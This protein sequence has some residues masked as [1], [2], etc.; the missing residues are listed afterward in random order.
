MHK[1]PSV[2]IINQNI[3]QRQLLKNAL[4]TIEITQISETKD[5][6]SAIEIL[7]SEAF[8]LIITDI[9]LDQIDGWRLT[10]LIRSGVLK[11]A[12]STPIIIISTTF[13]ERIAEATA[14]EFEAN[15]FLPFENYLKLPEI[16]QTEFIDQK[17]EPQ[18][19]SILVIEDYDDT[20]TI[21]ERILKDRFDIES[22]SDGLSGLNAWKEKQHDIVLL[23]L[24]LPKLSGEEVLESIMRINPSQS[25]VMMTAFGSAEKAST[26][27]LKG[28]VDFISKPFRANQLRQVCNIAAHREDYIISNQQFIERQKQLSEEQ[29]RA[30]VTLK[31][32]GD[33]VI[34]TDAQGNIQYINPVA[35]KLTGWSNEEA[36]LK[37]LTD[38]FQTYNEI[39]RTPAT[40]PLEQCLVQSRTI[41]NTNNIFLRN[42]YAHELVIEH[43]ASP[44]RD[45]Y[46]KVAG[47][48]MVF[49]DSTEARQMQQQL[50]YHASHDNLTGL[51]NR[52][53]FD[54]ELKNA[55]GETQGSSEEHNLCHL[56]LNQFKHIN[57]SCG[58][59]AGD[60][61]LQE[62]S[63]II[64]RQVRGTS[65]II[66]R[67][68]G[69]EF[70]ILLRHCPAHAAIRIAEKI[71]K[72]IEDYH[73]HWEGTNYSVG[74]SVGIVS[75]NQYSMD[76]LDT[77]A[78][79]EA[80]C[81]IAKEH[82]GNRVHVYSDDD[83][84]LV[85]RRSE[86]KVINQLVT[87]EKENRFELYCQEIRPIRSNSSSNNNQ[88]SSYEIL[89]RMRDEDNQLLA[90]G[91][92]LGAAERYNMMKQIDQWVV[93]N[94]LQQLS[95]HPDLF[96]HISHFS[97]NLSALSLCDDTCYDFI[98]AQFRETDVAPNRICFEIT[99]TAAISNFIRAGGFISAIRELGCKFALDDFGSG[100]SS[101]AYLKKLPVDYLKI[102]GMFV[103][104]VLED[105]IDYEMVRSINEIGHVLNLQTIAEFVENADILKV[106]SKMGVDFAQGYHLSKPEPL[107]EVIQSLSQ[108]SGNSLS[109]T[110]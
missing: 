29:E 79:A 71:C 34:T 32:I 108:C 106:I 62:L 55:L 93:R 87:A 82:G 41:E 91:Q 14:K 63:D 88:L 72:S 69:D 51:R 58:H 1:N 8:D 102:D 92:F 30:L 28:A 21:V 24:M 66:A 19:T 76:I 53:T 83:S 110:P 84:E 20:V 57:D 107:S 42:R 25:V 61:L 33:G 104:G 73:F 39:S 56:N 13:S 48:V 54:N 36:H 22:A 11:S 97:I 90:P 2:L 44:I 35:E 81:R 75:I 3:E 52:E 99:E 89:I 67:L 95:K 26:L 74:I 40:N 43:S 68:G 59:A 27:I 65:D 78:A 5:G 4:Q 38:I 98:A 16:I 70:G 7:N 64:S 96:N 9:D 12:A 77:L 105:P 101:F 18:K 45:R 15:L 109:G 31:S 85:Q 80:S 103:K 60:K 17:S 86:M 47:A 49:R 6:L 10:R 46:Q 100:M 50:S 37:P 94:S 23:D